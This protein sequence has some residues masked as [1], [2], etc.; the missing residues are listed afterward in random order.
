M[1]YPPRVARE[2]GRRSGGARLSRSAQLGSPFYSLT[3][4]GMEEPAT[5][6]TRRGPRPLGATTRSAVCHDAPEAA[7]SRTA[8]G[9]ACCLSRA[10][11]APSFS[12]SEEGTLRRVSGDRRDGKRHL[13]LRRAFSSFTTR[14]DHVPRILAPTRT[15]LSRL[16]HGG[17]AARRPG[18]SRSFV[19]QACTTCH[20]RRFRDGLLVAREALP[21]VPPEQISWCPRTTSSLFARLRQ[22]PRGISG[23]GVS[24][25]RAGRALPLL[26]RRD[27]EA[28]GTERASVGRRGNARVPQPHGSA[29]TGML[30]EPREVLT[31]RGSRRGACLSPQAG[32]RSGLRCHDAHRSGEGLRRSSPILCVDCHAEVADTEG[33]LGRR[34]ALETVSPAPTPRWE[35]ML[36]HP[37]ALCQ[38][39][40]GRGFRSPPRSPVRDELHELPRSQIG[41]AKLLLAHEPFAAGECGVCHDESRGDAGPGVCEGVTTT[42]ASRPGSAAATPVRLGIAS[43]T[44]RMW[45]GST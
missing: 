43:C 37:S 34:P 44:I 4:R 32:G 15:R 42:F 36:P 24:R 41:P 21:V 28:P 35:R 12:R 31:C 19:K 5:R 20:D 16:P 23:R 18:K 29:I 38:C 9:G 45:P 14:T 10:A 1:R 22:L 13:R 3:R 27:R 30:E 39:P 2:V 8:R 33:R 17:V 7:S 11:G 40:T 25:R 6:R 26:P